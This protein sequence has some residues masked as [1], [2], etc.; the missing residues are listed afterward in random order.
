[1]PRSKF[2]QITC[3]IT[4]ES[5]DLFALAADGTVYQRNWDSDRWEPLASERDDD[6]EEKETT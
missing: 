6:E 2:V 1:M 4:D 5:S 3:A